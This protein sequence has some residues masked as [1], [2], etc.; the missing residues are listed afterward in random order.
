VDKEIIVET[1]RYG[2]GGGGCNG[3]AWSVVGVSFDGWER[4]RRMKGGFSRAC[5]GGVTTD[6]PQVTPFTNTEQLTG[7]QQ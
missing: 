5:G 7:F 6:A 1:L 2:W 4:V 3:G